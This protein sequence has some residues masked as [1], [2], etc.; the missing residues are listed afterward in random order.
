MCMNIV[1]STSRIS[2]Y[3]QGFRSACCFLWVIDFCPIGCQVYSETP[4]CSQF[5]ESLFACLF[6]VI[7]IQIQEEIHQF[8]GWEGGECQGAPKLWTRHSWTKL[9]LS[10]SWSPPRGNISQHGFRANF[11]IS[12]VKIASRRGSPREKRKTE[13]KIQRTTNLFAEFSRKCSV[14][15]FRSKNR[16]RCRKTVS[17]DFNIKSQHPT[18]A[19][20]SMPNRRSC[21]SSQCAY[22]SSEISIRKLL[23]VSVKFLSAI[24]GPE[25]A[26][27]P[28]KSCFSNRVLVKTIF[29]APK[30]L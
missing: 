9:A 4:L 25:M 8:A 29:E 28:G 12:R 14:C 6:E 7:L 11:S 23:L 15:A 5:C 2:V 20:S 26:R 18:M 13:R 16:K 19:Q 30:C 10:I 3:F 24:L 22:A 17:K 27:E 1:N 21:K